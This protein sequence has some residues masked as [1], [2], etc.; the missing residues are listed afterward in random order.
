M[1][2]LLSVFIDGKITKTIQTVKI[3]ARDEGRGATMKCKYAVIL[4]TLF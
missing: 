4:S 1:E 3:G 2:C